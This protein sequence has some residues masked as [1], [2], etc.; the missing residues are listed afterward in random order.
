M[1]NLDA[2]GF[3]HSAPCEKQAAMQP[4]STTWRE[5]AF[6]GQ[7]AEISMQKPHLTQMMSILRK[8][9]LHFEVTL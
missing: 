4:L 1:Y 3:N 7:Y 6:A 5:S 2:D 9:C 8:C